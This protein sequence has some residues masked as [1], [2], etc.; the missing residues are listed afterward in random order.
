MR[1][2]RRA[3]Q[4]SCASKQGTI[5]CLSKSHTG[6]YELPSVKIYLSGD[7]P[8]DPLVKN[9]HCNTRGTLLI[10]GA[11]MPHTS[12]SK[13]QN[14]RQSN[15]VTN[16]IKTFKKWLIF[17]KKTLKKKIYVFLVDAWTF[18]EDLG[19]TYMVHH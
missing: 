10:P 4:R 6:P 1:K 5:A 3:S 2:I 11:K 12:W 13:N 9:P 8:V 7:F 15:I 14:M 16:S 17:F 19:S 18:P